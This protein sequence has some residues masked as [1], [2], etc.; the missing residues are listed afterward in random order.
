MKKL[1]SISIYSLY[2]N[3]YSINISFAL[4]FV[5]Q[6]SHSIIHHSHSHLTFKVPHWSLFI[7]I[8]SYFYFHCHSLNHYIITNSST[9]FTLISTSTDTKYHHWTSPHFQYI[10][11]QPLL[12]LFPVILCSLS[13]VPPEITPINITT[14]IYTLSCHCCCC[15]PQH[16]QFLSLS[17]LLLQ[18]MPLQLPSS[19]P[20]TGN[21][22]PFKH[23]VYL[24]NPIKQIIW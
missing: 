4:S 6:I 1:I 21:S 12:P 10:K 2:H 16:Q 14:L 22:S 9:I 5:I 18:Q 19:F 20:I 15:S 13:S 3:Y 17:S 24:C 7:F 11:P 8:H 23:K